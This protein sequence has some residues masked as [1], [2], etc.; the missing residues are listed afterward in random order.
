[1]K[2]L[3][4]VVCLFIVQSVFSQTQT[5]PLN[6]SFS[7][8]NLTHWEA[9]TGNN[10][11]GNSSSSIKQIY[12]S[13]TAAP[14]GTLGNNIIY[15]YG[16]AS[17]PAIQVLSSS[18]TDAFGSFPTVPK[19]NGYQ[20]TNSILLG[21]TAITRSSGSGVGGGY[22]R[23][24]RY[25]INVPAGPPDLPYTMTYAYAMILENG[26]H[27]SAQQP[28]FQATLSVKDSIIQCASPQ[29]YLPTLNNAD[30][31]G[32]GA[33]LDTALAVSNGF[34]LSPMASPNPSQNGGGYLHDVWAKGWTEVTFDLSPWRGQQVVLTFET[35]NC[36][37]GGH[38]AY[39]YIAL[40]NVCAGLSISGP[41]VACIGSTLTYSIPALTGGSYHW[42]VPG[43]WSIVSSPDSAI[44]QVKIGNDVGQVTVNEQNSCANLNAILPVTT[45]PPTIAGGLTGDAEVCTGT[46]S[47]KLTLTG[48]RGDVLNWLASTDGIS[49]TTINNQTAQYTAQDLTATTTYKALVQNGGSCSIDTSGP[50]I[51]QVD[52]KTV[53]GKL[54][55]VTM[56]FCAGQDKDALLTLVNSVGDPVNWQS[57]TDAITWTDFSP[58]YKEKQ[59][60]LTGLSGPIR[61]RVVVQS[62][63]CPSEISAPANIDFVNVPFPQATYSPADTLICYQGTA[64]LNATIQIGT[65]YAWS[66]TDN[67][68][69]EG[70]GTIA[71][72]P[73]AIQAIVTPPSTTQ[74]VLNIE[75]AGCPNLLKDTFSI[76][77]MP[78]VIVDAGRDTSVVINQPLQLHATSDDTTTLGG[79]AFAW[80][81]I[82]GL[83]NPTISDPI[84]LYS[85]ETDSVRYTVTATTGMG[86]TGSAQ[87]LVRVFKTDPDIFVPNAFTPTG[88]A[89]T[90]FRPIAPGIASLDYFMVYNRW[91]QL[92]YQTSRLGQ[93]WNGYVNGKPAASG[94]YVWMV[95]G[96]T[97]NGKT[98]YHR[99]T[100]V[101]VR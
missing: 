99:G 73:Y 101:L 13:N 28:L 72:T 27:N 36:V 97:Y 3:L 50:A 2:H 81:P 20:Y 29:Y 52:P 39:S 94:G 95:Q 18:T 91:G 61:Y 69:G 62:G 38:F 49:Y 25:R 67:F 47:S 75:N 37:P 80:A 53:G 22:V 19:I 26:T 5:C 100:M 43:D 88:P 23:G 63:V 51:V 32:Q 15:E 31:R 46:N 93:G 35:D 66:S 9:Y 42:T 12:D 60:A 86:C 98:V 44:I 21:S 71:G 96:K 55:P 34:Y 16:L 7:M 70:S 14:S 83:N 33:K 8:G 92:M 78:P 40:R 89:N 85:A 59:Y 82:I 30:G 90:V 45:S 56:E 10:S 41:D 77:V 74:Y 11:G 84:G 4:P 76:R 79:D 1:M 57:S 6:G 68:T 48:N 54:T 17:M 24:V 87:V 58:A 65:N 64:T